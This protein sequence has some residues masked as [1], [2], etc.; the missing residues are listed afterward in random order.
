MAVGDWY[1]TASLNV[2]IDGIN[3]GEGCIP[4]NLNDMGRAIMANVKV[5]YNSSLILGYNLFIEEEGTALP[6]TPPDNTLVFFYEV[7]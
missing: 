4:A 5:M 2:T 1:T 3:I 7:P 6:S